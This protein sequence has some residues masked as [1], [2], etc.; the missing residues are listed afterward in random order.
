[1]NYQKSFFWQ[2]E[3]RTQGECLIRC[4]HSIDDHQKPC[5]DLR[6]DSIGPHF[7]VIPVADD[8][9]L[10]RSKNDEPDLGLCA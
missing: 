8:Y 9:H 3:V 10:V 6:M 7:K 5:A 2:T 4:L 1:M